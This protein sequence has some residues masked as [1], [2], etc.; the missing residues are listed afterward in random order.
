M[1]TR[2]TVYRK[3]QRSA[4]LKVQAISQKPL[5]VFITVHRGN[6][7]KYI[8]ADTRGGFCRHLYIQSKRKGG[9][10]LWQKKTPGQYFPDRAVFFYRLPFFAYVF[11]GYYVFSSP[12]SRT[13]GGIWESRLSTSSNMALLRVPS[14]LAR[15]RWCMTRWCRSLILSKN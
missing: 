9:S 4:V 14:L 5:S 3:L 1:G 8:D 6:T 13:I 10:T 2:R 11:S 15:F 7:G 12:I